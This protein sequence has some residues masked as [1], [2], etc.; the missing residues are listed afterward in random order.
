MILLTFF[1]FQ[2]SSYLP[3]LHTHLQKF[4]VAME[5]II[6]TDPQQTILDTN[7]YLIQVWIFLYIQACKRFRQFPEPGHHIYTICGC[8]HSVHNRLHGASSLSN[9]PRHSLHDT[10]ISSYDLQKSPIPMANQPNAVH[11]P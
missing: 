4:S 11:Y 5:A 6:Q 2:I 9:C 10:Q 8:L 1:F 7:I 3:S